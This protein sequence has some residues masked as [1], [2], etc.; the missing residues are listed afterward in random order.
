MSHDSKDKAG[1]VSEVAAYLTVRN[2][3][4]ALAFY[5][6][7]FGAEEM[8]R[9]TEPSGKVGHAEFRIGGTLMQIADEYPDFGAL[10]PV[11]V[12]GCP[13]KFTI[14]VDD[15]EAAVAKAVAAG[16]QVTRKIEKQ[17][18]GYLTGMIADPFGYSWFLQQNV[19]H[20][21]AEE[22]QARWSDVFKEG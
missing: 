14:E 10:S 17:F 3:D 15:V 19:D 12:G 6:Q 7:A 20:L 1:I 11:S 16:A 21:S 8:F 5:K 13:V 18:Y 2:A 22:M 4:K 9:L